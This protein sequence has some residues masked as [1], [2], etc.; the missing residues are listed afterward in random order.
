MYI[1]DVLC[2]WGVLSLLADPGMGDSEDLGVVSMDVSTITD[3]AG[4]CNYVN[5][6][7]PLAA[8]WL[9]AIIY[10]HA[11]VYYILL[12]Q[13]RVY[14]SAC[15]FFPL[16]LKECIYINFVQINMWNIFRTGVTVQDNF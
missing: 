12:H 16:K 9:L 10:T 1:R 11:V 6:R 15:T 8:F 13:S 7:R 2:R 14:I 3:V 4:A 5:N